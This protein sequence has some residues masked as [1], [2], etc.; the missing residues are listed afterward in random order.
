MEKVVRFSKKSVKYTIAIVNWLIYSIIVGGTTTPVNDTFSNIWYFF[1]IL[2]FIYIIFVSYYRNVNYKIIFLFAM[3]MG[4]ISIVTYTS[5]YSPLLAWG[6]MIFAVRNIECDFI[7]SVYF[8]TFIVLGILIPLMAVTGLISNTVM[9]TVGITGKRYAYGFTH[10]NVLGAVLLVIVICWC[11]L[12]WKSIKLYHIVI[13]N[14]LSYGMMQITDSSSSFIC[15][16]FI[17]V[18]ALLERWFDKK[19]KLNLWYFGIIVLLIFCPAISYYFMVKYTP[20]N[21]LMLAIDLFTTGRLRTMNAFFV[22]Y[23][24]KILGNPIIFDTER[25]SLLL[26]ALD[27]S[28]GYILIRFGIIVSLF[29]FMG[30]F[31]VIKRAIQIRDTRIIICV[32]TFLVYGLFENYFFKTQFNFTLLFIF[33][34]YYGNSNKLHVKKGRVVNHED[35]SHYISWCR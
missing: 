29:Y 7:V 12:H 15:I 30:I 26:F 1:S 32:L 18:I 23:G 25:R 21:P 5:N 8:K 20:S 35:W 2:L 16:A 3:V 22:K 6:L 17:S 11:Y 33:A 24:V 4:V 10:P 31:K 28:Y 14:L 27:N 19:S 34:N 13:I 9:D